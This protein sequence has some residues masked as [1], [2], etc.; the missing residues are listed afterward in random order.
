MSKT[1]MNKH[2]EKIK[3]CQKNGQDIYQFAPEEW[4]K[5]LNKTREKKILGTKNVVR[6]FIDRGFDIINP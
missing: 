1:M 2:N 6:E 5:T 3:E 4:Y